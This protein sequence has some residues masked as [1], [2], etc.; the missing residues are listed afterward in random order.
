[1]SQLPLGEWIPWLSLLPLIPSLHLGCRSDSSA[2]APPI[3]GSTRD[4]RAYGSTGL[5]LQ[6][7][8]QPLI[9]SLHLGC[10]SDS[11]AFAPPFLGS[12]RDHQGYGSTGLPWTAGS[13]SVRLRYGPM[14]HLLH[15]V[16]PPLWLL[17][18]PPYLRLHLSPPV[19]RFHLRGSSL[20]LC[21]G[22]G[23]P[24]NIG[25]SCRNIGSPSAPRAPL[26]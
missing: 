26:P 20:Q 24:R 14:R 23:S 19:P 21:R 17:L 15:F 6:L 7:C 16:S 25:T 9:P 13:A 12:T 8:L 3:L 22:L 4:H 2:F 5:F 1:M 11:F 10:R 18:A